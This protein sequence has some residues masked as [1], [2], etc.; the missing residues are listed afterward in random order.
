MSENQDNYDPETDPDV[1]E[2]NQ[3]PDD[4]EGGVFSK[5]GEKIMATILLIV[6]V[7]AVLL[8]VWPD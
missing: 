7:G 6:I 8:V 2:A 4:W 1:I 3:T 5:H